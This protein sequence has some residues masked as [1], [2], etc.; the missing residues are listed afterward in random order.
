M[1]KLVNIAFLLIATLGLSA[2]THA[3][4][5]DWS[6]NYR[7]EYV[8][9]DKTSL[10]S[11]GLRKAYM[12]NHLSLSPKIIAADGVN[13]VAKFEILSND[14]YPESQAGQPF[15]RGPKKAGASSST[16]DDSAVAGQK[17]GVSAIS[18]SQ[19]Y[20]TM[21]QEYGSLLVG[22][23]PLEFGLG[24]THSAGNGPFDHWYDVRD[25]VAYKFLV[26]N[27]S[28]MPMIGKVYDY[29]V[30]QGRAVQDV[31]FNLLYDNQETESAI[32]IIHQTRSAS[33]LANDAPVS[34]F[35]G[36]GVTGD[37]NTQH[38]NLYISRGFEPVKIKLE[39]G[40]ESG[41][42]GVSKS[43]E[44]VKL[45]GYG[46]ALDLD[47]PPGEGG[48]W[49]W[50]L[51]AGMA[52]GDDPSTT[53]YEGFHFDRNYDVAF[54]MFNHPL[55]RY[56]LLRSYAQRSPDRSCTT[57]PCAPY[58]SDEALD[59]EAIS[60]T[61]YVSP[62]LT[63]T[64]NDRWQWTNRLTWAQ[65]QTKPVANADIAKDLGFEYDIG[66]VFKPHERIQWVNELGLLFPG[67]AFKGTAAQ[68]FGN[69]F[70][71]GISSKASFSF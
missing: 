22:R 65:L 47:F 23:A 21:N 9:V 61:V 5:I 30:A 54:L 60:N 63:Y 56:D 35:G 1:R 25:V 8:E 70:T 49:N 12:L 59:D 4:S 17:N 3:M 69:G 44:E 29:S 43:N 15:G 28:F 46:I 26:G 52:T 13:I 42:T 27:L 51:R 50:G 10:D 58:A 34:Q 20:L 48:K 11:P 33:L 36:T 64:M 41:N 38:I 24:M 39:A 62:R 55:G 37:W 31:T 14:Q 32:G 53:A 18:V 67:S 40:F 19:L 6:G 16:K 66:F 2:S 71:Y 45:A 57:A 7:V 68:N